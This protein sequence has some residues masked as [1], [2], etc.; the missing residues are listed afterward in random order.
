MFSKRPASIIFLIIIYGWLTNTLASE[1][2]LI[3]ELHNQPPEPCISKPTDDKSSLI[4]ISPKGKT[5]EEI[6]DHM[7]AFA[8]VFLNV[9]SAYMTSKY[10]ETVYTAIFYEKE[11][12]NEVGIYGYRFKE[13]IDSKLFEAKP[14]LNGKLFVFNNKLLV[15]L[16]HEDI[17]RTGQCFTAMEK[18]LLKYTH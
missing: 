6:R 17:R 10:I 8:S 16:W 15:V 9:G 4:R 1:H 12:I 11:P 18:V 7:G 14:E 13:S 5:R 3:E 2:S